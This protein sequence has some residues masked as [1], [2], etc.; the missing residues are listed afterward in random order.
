MN[1]VFPQAGRRVE[2]INLF[3]KYLT[4]ED[5]IFI[6]NDYDDASTN[7]L[8]NTRLSEARIEKVCIDAVYDHNITNCLI[9][10]TLDTQ[11]EAFEYH[12][13]KMNDK[14][15][16]V[17][18]NANVWNNKLLVEKLL[19]ANGIKTPKSGYPNY[20]LKEGYQYIAKPVS[21]SGSRNILISYNSALLI[22]FCDNTKER[23]LIQEYISGHEYTI[24]CF[25]NDRHELVQAV[26]RKRDFVR[27]GEVAISTAVKNEK[28]ISLIR[29]IFYKFK[30]LGP[31]TVQAI[32][33]N[34]GEVFVIE[35]NPRFGGGYPLTDYVLSKEV[36][37]DDTYVAYTIRMHKG[38]YIQPCDQM[39][40]EVIDVPHCMTRYDQSFF[41]RRDNEI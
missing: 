17:S 35:I 6:T 38:E 9:I 2:L 14:S 27:S 3:R 37:P 7:Q 11:L 8:V 13:Y 15:F 40:S 29:D 5:K 28:I 19:L 34:N 26:A 16:L 31:V 41:F 30:F 21:G 10:P 22:N 36:S 39:Y 32:E 33:T 20:G 25:A 18:P 4:K 12:R 24:D 1:I 23:M